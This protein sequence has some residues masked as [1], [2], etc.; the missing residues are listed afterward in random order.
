MFDDGQMRLIRENSLNLLPIK[1]SVG[2]RAGR[3]YRGPLAGVERSKLD[4]GTI[5]RLCHYAAQRVYFT[6]QMAFTDAADSRIAAHLAQSCD[7]LCNQ[8]CP[9]ARSRG[10]QGG[11]R[12]GVTAA[13]YDD[14]ELF[15]HVNV[16]Q[17]TNSLGRAF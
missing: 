6:R 5:Y 14:I 7:A 9:G 2:L 13:N 17:K 11:F 8:Q 16:A 12:T 1:R 4:A 10:S 3:P 15:R